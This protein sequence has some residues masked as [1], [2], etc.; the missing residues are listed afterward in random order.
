MTS[1]C[2]PIIMV[3]RVGL[4][5]EKVTREG[6]FSRRGPPPQLLAAPSSM[7]EPPWY[8]GGPPIP[9]RLRPPLPHRQSR[10]GRQR[11]SYFPSRR[12]RLAR[13]SPPPL[14]HTHLSPGENIASA[15]GRPIG[16]QE[17]NRGGAVKDRGGEACNECTGRDWVG[18]K[19]WTYLGIPPHALA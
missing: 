19:D 18:Q 10:T 1:D 15:S 16:A 12:H 3:D 6:H 7:H 17:P 8:D 13:Q 11:S 4:G 14:P 5:K 2:R 9:G